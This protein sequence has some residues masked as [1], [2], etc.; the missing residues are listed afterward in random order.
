MNVPKISLFNF[1]YKV[2]V[3]NLIGFGGAPLT[4]GYYQKEFVEPGHI[5]LNELNQ[6]VA[7][8]NL[9]PGAMSFYVSGYIGYRLFNKRGLIIGVLTCVIPIMI[10]TLL[11]YFILQQT[12]VNLDILIMFVLPLIIVNTYKYALQL[13]KQ[14]MNPIIKLAIFIITLTLLLLFKISSIQLVVI[15]LFFITIYLTTNKELK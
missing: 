15:Y 6:Y 3:I 12:N 8:A 9:L 4:V 2:L 10:I 14:Q 13:I 7:L 5:T 1:W 11:T